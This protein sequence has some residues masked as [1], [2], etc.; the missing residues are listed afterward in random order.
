MASKVP[1]TNIPQEEDSSYGFLWRALNALNNFRTAFDTLATTISAVFS[2]GAPTAAT[3]IAQ[4]TY[5]SIQNS[6]GH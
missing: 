4:G 5:T 3:A 1:S 6:P 2:P